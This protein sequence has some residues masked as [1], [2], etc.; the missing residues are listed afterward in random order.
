MG[1]LLIDR[2]AK[3]VEYQGLRSPP[4]SGLLP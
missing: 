4:R 1:A 3:K 2:W